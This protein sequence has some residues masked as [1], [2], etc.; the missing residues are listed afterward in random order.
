[1]SGWFKSLIE[2]N[3]IEKLALFYILVSPQYFGMRQIEQLLKS[4]VTKIDY[5]EDRMKYNHLFDY[6]DPVNKKFWLQANMLD[7]KLFTSFVH[8][9]KI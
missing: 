9:K 5:G 7:S 1:M 3:K 4:A 8:I 6:D 2:T